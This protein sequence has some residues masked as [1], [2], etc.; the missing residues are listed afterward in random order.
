M[1][2][3]HSSATSAP[4]AIYQTLLPFFPLQF[5]SERGVEGLG[6]RLD[7]GGVAS[8]KGHAYAALRNVRNS[9]HDL[10]VELSLCIYSHTDSSC[11]G[12]WLV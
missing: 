6:T 11:P 9:A 8:G 5:S 10:S 2:S 3:P 1:D 7:G 12:S 4:M